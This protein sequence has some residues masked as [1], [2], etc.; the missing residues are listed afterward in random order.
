MFY[1]T[2]SF[3]LFIL[4]S[5]T[6]LAYA[7]GSMYGCIKNYSSCDGELLSPKD[8]KGWG[9]ID[10]GNSFKEVDDKVIKKYN[11]VLEQERDWSQFY[12]N[13]INVAGL[14]INSIVFGIVDDTA[15]F[16][17]K[18][19]LK[20]VYLI[21]TSNKYK[22]EKVKEIVGLLAKKYGRPTVIEG[23]VD[24]GDPFIKDSK[25]YNVT[26]F[27]S[28]WIF[29]STNIVVDFKAMSELK[30]SIKNN[31]QFKSDLIISYTKAQPI[32]GL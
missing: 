9:G 24:L 11:K 6:T 4:I 16:S 7:D 32:S 18:G 31:K 1:T 20:S 21:H 19:K 27:Y 12:I 8:V 25:V 2:C 14:N 29:P 30:D 28:K 22:A 17:K 10:W 23:D 3:L 5:W 26:K 15:N 13:D